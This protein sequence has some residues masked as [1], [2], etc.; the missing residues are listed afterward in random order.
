MLKLL[1]ATTP[2]S[3]TVIGLY[4]NRSSTSRME[5]VFARMY[6]RVT[7]AG[8]PPKPA[9]GRGAQ[10]VRWQR[11]LLAPVPHRRADAQ[12]VRLSA[13]HETEAR[14]HHL[15][16]YTSSS[17][18]AARRVAA[19]QT[20]IRQYRSSAREGV[21]D[22]ARGRDTEC[23]SGLGVHARRAHR[24]GGARDRARRAAVRLRGA[25]ALL[26]GSRGRYTNLRIIMSR[27]NTAIFKFA[28]IY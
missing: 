14:R 6:G 13:S 16:R 3:F 25:R 5:I 27:I 17:H 23:G 10:P 1:P 28:Y 7:A 20:F 26:G 19:R 8:D 2:L 21:S 15:R 22:R 24:V 18:L 11:R 12:G 9:A 4:G